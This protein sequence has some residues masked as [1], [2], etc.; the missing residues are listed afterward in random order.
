MYYVYLLKFRNQVSSN[1]TA[2][3]YL[4]AKTLDGQTYAAISAPAVLDFVPLAVPANTR[5]LIK[6][7]AG[8]AVPG[9]SVKYLSQMNFDPN[10]VKQGNTGYGFEVVR[11]I[12]AAD[13]SAANE[14]VSKIR[15]E[16]DG[17]TVGEDIVQPGG[18]ADDAM[19]SAST[20]TTEAPTTTTTEASTTTTEGL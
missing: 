8:S 20:T 16:N 4:L 3:R 14:L 15:S 5:L 10:R 13:E 6:V 12:E 1:A 17:V 11:I 7:G 9:D 19:P 2:M 18:N